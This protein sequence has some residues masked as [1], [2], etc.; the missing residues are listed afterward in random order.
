MPCRYQYINTALYDH[1]MSLVRDQYMRLCEA[2]GAKR[3]NEADPDSQ[4]RKHR[5]NPRSRPQSKVHEPP[6]F[7]VKDKMQKMHVW[8]ISRALRSSYLPGKAIV[9]IMAERVERLGDRRIK[10][11]V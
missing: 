4:Q 9:D 5:Y 11:V 7:A 3:D 10:M 1:V 6:S 2:Q 8:L